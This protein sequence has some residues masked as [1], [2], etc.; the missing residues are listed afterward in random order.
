MVLATNI[1]SCRACTG[2]LSEGTESKGG[3]LSGGP[4]GRSRRAGEFIA[5]HERGRGTLWSSIDILVV[6]PEATPAARLQAIKLKHE[7]GKDTDVSIITAADL[8][9]VAEKWRKYSKDGVFS[10]EVFNSTGILSR[11]ELEAR[12]GIFLK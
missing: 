3:I 1:E 6:V 4:K 11:Q 5:P 10:L 9:F 7:S 8:K 12:M 2:V